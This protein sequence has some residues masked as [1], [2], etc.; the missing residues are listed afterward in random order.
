MPKSS[1]KSLTTARFKAISDDLAHSYGQHP[2]LVGPDSP[3]R[4]RASAIVELIDALRALM[5]PGFF[6]KTP[7]LAPGHP[8]SEKPLETL[9]AL[10]HEQIAS[11]LAYKNLVSARNPGHLVCDF[12][13]RIPNVRKILATDIDAAFEGDPATSGKDEIIL[14]YPGIHAIMVNRLAR[15]LHKLEVPLLPR[16]MTEC[17]HGQ[18]GID[19]HPGAIIGHHFFI[20]HGTGVVIGETTRIGNYVKIYQG[21]T[22]G[23]L[24]TRGGRLLNGLKRHPT[25]ED[26]VTIYSGASI[27]GGETIIGAGAVIGSNAFITRSVPGNT[28]VSLKDPELQFMT[29]KQDISI[30]FRQ[31]TFWDYVI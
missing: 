3:H 2:D 26:N 11:A 4:I 30:E 20:D 5:F 18:T 27:L 6:S 8:W 25:I 15:E 28:R 17:A 24:S 9:A 7:T 10:L 19:I 12:L 31:D 21:V 23:A 13:E 16:M 29:Q 1:P 22:L 14:A